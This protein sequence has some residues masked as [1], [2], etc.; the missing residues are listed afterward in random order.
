[1]ALDPNVILQGTRQPNFDPLGEVTRGAQAVGIFAKLRQQEEEAPIRQAILQNQADLLAQKVATGAAEAQE[2]T[3]KRD[4]KGLGSSYLQVKGDIAAGN[5]NAAADQLQVIHDRKIAAGQTP[6]DMSAHA[7]AIETLRSNDAKAIK[8]LKALGQGAIDAAVAEGLLEDPAAAAVKAVP[9][10]VREIKTLHEMTKSDDENLV[11]AAEIAL[12]VLAKEGTKTKSERLGEDPE[13]TEKVAA[14]EAIIE[15][16]KTAAKET[17]KL[18]TQ[19]KLEPAVKSAV[20]TAVAKAKATVDALGTKRDNQIALQVYDT[21]V[22]GLVK[23]LGGTVTGPLIGRAPA[24][25]ANQQIA[26]GA[27][28]AMA[29]VLKQLFRASSEGTFTDQDQKLLLDMVPTRK[30]EPE[31]RI[32]KIQNINAIV[33]AKLSVPQETGEQ[34]Q[35]GG[36]GDLSDDEFKELLR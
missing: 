33:R 10:K 18:S 17:A 9:A 13:L 30:D 12:G 2:A 28:A 4:L 22:S 15:G 36:L 14:S 6:E 35:S 21:A 11:K 25:T 8:D 3:R 19:L 5:Y 23:S 1:M 20:A 16:E 32:A 29:P 26:D 7:Q 27:V 24:F 31:A 34:Q